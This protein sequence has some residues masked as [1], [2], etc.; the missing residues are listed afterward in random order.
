II[1]KLLG[2][3]QSATTARYAHLDN[4]PLRRAPEAIAGR[5]AAAMGEARKTTGGALMSLK[6]VRKCRMCPA[7]ARPIP[8]TYPRGRFLWSGRG[9]QRASDVTLTVPGGMRRESLK[10]GAALPQTCCWPSAT[11]WRELMQRGQDQR[12]GSPSPNVIGW[13]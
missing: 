11:A 6:R 7:M 1:G 2:H 8:S 3:S 9:L 10:G 12:F 4:D 13:I 5:I